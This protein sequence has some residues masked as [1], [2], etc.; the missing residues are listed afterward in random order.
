MEKLNYMAVIRPD[1]TFTVSV[2]SQFFSTEHYPLRGGNENF[3]VPEESS[4]RG[5]LYLDRE[6]T[7][8]ASFSDTD[9]AKCYF[10]RRSTTRNCVFLGENL[11]MKKQKSRV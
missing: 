7:R 6:H 5:L 2:M 11:V 10:A 4:G 9:W 8:V 1:I 3:E